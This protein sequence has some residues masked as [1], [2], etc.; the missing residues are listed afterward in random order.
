MKITAVLLLA[1]TPVSFRS[2]WLISRACRPTCESP[3][4]PSSS[5]FGTR[6][7][8]E[9]MT[10]TSTALDLMSISA[11]CIASS[12]LPG[13]LTSSVSSSTPSFLAQ[14]GSRACSASMKAAM[15]PLRWAWATTCRASVVLPLDSGP[16]ISTTRPRGMPWPPRAMS[17]ERLPVGMPVIWR[18][19]V[20]AQGHDGP[21]AEL[22]LDLGDGD[23]QGRVGSQHRF[24]I[25]LADWPFGRLAGL[26]G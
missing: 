18:D 20:G 17:S 4:S 25:R 24:A 3:I 7:A 6:A 2:D 5:F 22:L 12:P 15:P 8:T 9:S 19:V 21:F 16:K 13:W 26:G 11:M 23:F 10:I 14:P 1:I